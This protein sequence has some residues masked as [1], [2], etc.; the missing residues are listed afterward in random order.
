MS[1]KHPQSESE[2]IEKMRLFETN[3]NEAMD[4]PTPRDNEAKMPHCKMYNP[5][6]ELKHAAVFV[7]DVYN[8]GLCAQHLSL[9]GC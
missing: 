1:T 2:W 7:E 6:M 8:R 3:E 5:M 4:P 9:Y